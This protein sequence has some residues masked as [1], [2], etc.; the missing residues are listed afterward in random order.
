M[1]PQAQ[2]LPKSRSRTL[3]RT[4]AK[5]ALTIVVTTVW[6]VVGWQYWESPHTVHSLGG[7]LRLVAHR[8]H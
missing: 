5:V 8:Y 6:V 4:A 1:T 3:R 2:S 7:V